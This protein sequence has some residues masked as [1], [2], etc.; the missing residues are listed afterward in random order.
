[1]P[2]WSHAVLSGL[3][4][5]QH[6]VRGG[7][8]P[9]PSRQAHSPSPSGWHRQETEENK[10]KGFDY[11]LKAAGAGDRQCMILV[12]RAF[13]TG[14]N[15]SPDRYCGCHPGARVRVRGGLGNW[16]QV[17]ASLSVPA[18]AWVSAVPVLAWVSAVPAQAWV[19]AVPA[20]AWVSAVPAQAWVSV[21]R[22]GIS[23]PLR[24]PG[25]RV[26]CPALPPGP[27]PRDLSSH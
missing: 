13:D 26:H 7:R 2:A 27:C 5:S 3:P 12:A 1:M 9:Q 19:S 17:G 14:Q 20:L 8:G 23:A 15:L 10:T 4:G 6:P 24:P 16:V 25:R 18:L 22:R 11:L 21:K